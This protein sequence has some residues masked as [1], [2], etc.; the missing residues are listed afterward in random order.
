MSVDA[1]QAL[2]LMDQLLETG[3]A[4]WPGVGRFLLVLTEARGRN[5]AAPGVYDFPRREVE[6]HPDPKVLEQVRVRASF[7]GFGTLVVKNGVVTFNSDPGLRARLIKA[8]AARFTAAELVMIRP[9]APVVV[10]QDA[11]LAEKPKPWWRRL[12]S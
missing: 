9:D 3:D 4:N 1:T 12:F 8:P 2:V 11:P 10:G 6:F 5:G 7:P